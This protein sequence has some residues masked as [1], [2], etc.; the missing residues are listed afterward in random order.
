MHSAT[1][2]V[3][4]SFD[5]MIDQQLDGV[6]M[7]SPLGPTLANIFVELYKHLLF[8]NHSKSLP[9]IKYVY[10]TLA[11]FSNEAELPAVS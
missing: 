8:N 3:E 4:F 2:S 5:N 10:D 6:F 1:T 7:G 11:I 9:Y